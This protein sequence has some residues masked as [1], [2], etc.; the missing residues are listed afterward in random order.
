MTA[1]SRSAI[2]TLVAAAG[3]RSHI[4]AVKS[5]NRE[6]IRALLK[7]ATDVNVR[8]ATGPRHSIASFT[9]N[10]VAQ[11]LLRAGAR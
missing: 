3:G 7:N 2:V 11:R 6:A 5:G 1:S 10:D 9:A 4:D 8:E